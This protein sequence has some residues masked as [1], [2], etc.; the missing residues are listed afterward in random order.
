MLELSEKFVSSIGYEDLAE[1]TAVEKMTRV[2]M[3]AFACSMGS[4]SCLQQMYSKL[5]SYIDDE[6]FTLPV[7]LQ[8]SVFCY[9]L[10]AST[11]LGDGPRLAETLWRKM[12]KSDNSEYRLRVIDALGC[13]NDVKGLFDL[14][15]T[16]LASTAEVRYLI[17]EN[18]EVVQSVYSKTP[19][20]VEA[21]LDFY[22]EFQSDAVRRT[23]KNGLVEILAEELSKRIF[24][25]RLKDKV[26]LSYV[27]KKLSQLVCSCVNS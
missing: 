22:T 16:I 26:R 3:I 21:T 20:G 25:Q 9:G 23:Q 14:L 19:E 17:S 13:Y 8:P 5:R 11:T 1:D 10:K 6:L 18:F 15:E 7:Y 12:Q 24:D 27:S 4:E 2:Q